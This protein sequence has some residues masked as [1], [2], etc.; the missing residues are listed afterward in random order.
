WRWMNA[1]G[2]LNIRFTPGTAYNYS[3]EG[4]EYLKMVVEKITGKKVERVLQEEVIQP[5]GLYHTFFSR[6]DSLRRMVANGH[7]DGMSNFDE[8]PESPGMAWSMHTEA[9]IFTNFMIYLLEQKGLSAKMYET[10]LQK[11]SEYS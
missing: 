8:L 9:T 3:G 2:K 6:N 11:H 1:D 5:V 7:Y 4:F 10:I